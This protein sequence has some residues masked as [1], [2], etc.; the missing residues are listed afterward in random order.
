MA[1]DA[2]KSRINAIMM[3]GADFIGLEYAHEFWLGAFNRCLVAFFA[4]AD[5]P[6]HCLRSFK[7]GS[8]S[9]CLRP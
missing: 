1:F 2:V 7:L 9:R 8:F 5:N 4:I 6:A 3:N